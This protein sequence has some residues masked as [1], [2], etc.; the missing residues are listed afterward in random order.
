MIYTKYHAFVVC[1][2]L[3]DS[4][5][6]T[7]VPGAVPTL[8]LP[9]KSFESAPSTSRRVLV[10]RTLPDVEKPK[11]LYKSLDDFKTKADRLLLTGWRRNASED[12]YVLEYFDAK[13]ALP[14]YS[15]RI[16]SGLEFDVYV[17]GWL[18][19]ESHQI[20]VEHKRLVTHLTI[21]TL[22]S[23]F[24]PFT[25]CPG[26]PQDEGILTQDPVQGIF[27]V[28]RH[29]VPHCHDAYPNDVPFSATVFIRSKD[30]LVLCGNSGEMCESCSIMFTAKVKEQRRTSTKKSA[31]LPVKAPLSVSSKERLVTTVRHQR[32]QCKELES[33]LTDMEREI[34]SNSI[35]VDDVLEGDIQ[36]ILAN[37]DMD[38]SPHMKFFL[39]QQK[40]LL[41]SPKFGR[42]YH[43]HL[44]RFCL[45]IH[46]KSPLVYRDLSESGVLVLPS[47]RVLRDYRNF[48]KPKPGFNQANV[49]KLTETT[50]QLFDV[51]RYVILSFD[52]MKIHSNL[53]FD[54]HSNELI[55]FLDLGDEDVNVATF[56]CPASMATH[57]LAFMV[58]GVASDL[59]YILGYFS[60]T[61]VTSYQI[62][63]LFWKAVAILEVACNLWVC[64]A[65]SNGA[66]PNR[67]FFVLHAGLMGENSNSDVVYRTINLFAPSRFI[68]FFSDAPHLLKTSRNCL[69]NSGIGKYTRLMWNCNKYIIWE[70]ISKLYYA[71]LE[72]GLHL[73]PKLTLDHVKL[74]SFSKMK[75]NLAAQTLSNSVAV[76]LRHHYPEGDAEETAKFCE[77]INKFFDC[78]NVRST[79]EHSRKRNPSLAPYTAVDDQRFEW[80]QNTFLKYLEEWYKATQTR[81]GTF[82]PDDRAKMFISQQTYSG[83][84]VSVNSIIEVAKFLISEGLEFVLSEKFCQDPLEE[85]FG[86]QRARGRYSDNPDLQRFGYNDLMIAAQRNIAPVVRGNVAGRHDGKKSKWFVVSDEPLP[87]RK[88]PSKE[89]DN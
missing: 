64:A 86:H 74:T 29:T 87:K 89:K 63:P 53:V 59:K 24:S 85:Y 35:E 66:S 77:M 4:S 34:K 18:L 12:T 20:Y 82:T 84:K 10:K 13:H 54:K 41:A 5:R 56:D 80:L 83:I 73:L 21:G 81:P 76:A 72:H 16:N 62:M 25:L 28:T 1:R 30:C 47:E 43:P 61:N 60:T 15:I 14:F 39:E 70:H 38:C 48:F 68:Y 33:R 88:P 50:N 6:K 26:L 52:E 2:N 37:S 7:L 3:I 23:L 19:P 27:D 57:V 69:Y 67:K 31:V 9:A 78:L 36:N 44:I 45:S 32:M 22:T 75:V 51:Q 49:Q 79:T 42:R 55:G 71:D 58:R 11:V 40:K 65:V 8:N 46:S 17:F